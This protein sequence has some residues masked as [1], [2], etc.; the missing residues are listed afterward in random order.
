MAF[1]VNKF[2]SSFSS[3]GEPANP[4]NYKVNIELPLSLK[5]KFDRFTRNIEYRCESVSIPESVIATMER[6]TYGVPLNIA[7]APSYGP[8]TISFI[9]SD[10]MDER[11]FFYD[12]KEL[13]SPTINNQDVGYFDDYVGNI[14]VN[15]YDKAGK[16]S[17][18]FT[19]NNCFPTNIQEVPL[20]WNANND[21]VRLNVVFKYTNISE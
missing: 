9:V 20:S 13:V 15:M 12:W 7:Y 2:R 3:T 10:N 21:Y 18:I 16:I 4:T 19:I 6:K 1:D 11:K 14:I 5:T 17:R 8:L